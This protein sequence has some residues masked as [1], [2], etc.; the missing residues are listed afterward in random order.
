MDVQTIKQNMMSLWKATFGDSSEYISLVFDRYFNPENIAYHEAEGKIAASLLGIPYTFV[1]SGNPDLKGLYLCGLATLPALRHNGIMTSLLQEINERAEKS[2]YDFT[3][4]IPSGEGIRR[5]YRDRGYHDAFY[6]KKEYYVKGHDFK[7][8]F[9]LELKVFDGEE[10]T[11]VIEFLEEYGNRPLQRKNSY[12]LRHTK[13]DWGT[14]LDDAL[15]SNDKIYIGYNDNA[16]CGLAICKMPDKVIDIRLLVG[17]SEQV[18]NSLLGKIAKLNSERN[19]TL[20]KDLED[21]LEHDDNKQLWSPFY[22]QNNGKTAEYEDVSVIEAPYN[23]SLNAFAMGMI[24]IFDIKTLLEKTGY[25]N[26]KNLDVYSEEEIKRLVLRKPVGH[27]ADALEKI[28][29]L[30]ELN[31]SMSMM[32]D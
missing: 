28:L 18:R 22:V 15:I 27:K 2:G 10:K 8:S 19:L 7:G 23:E 31:F 14:V 20:V 24:N 25:A 17:V 11:A 9:D 29:D 16:I 13:E 21:A 1:S 12:L 5:Y 6:K 30:P 26:F 32:L 3:F 4:L